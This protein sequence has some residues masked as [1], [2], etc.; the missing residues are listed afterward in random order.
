MNESSETPISEPTLPTLQDL[1]NLEIEVSGLGRGDVVHLINTHMGVMRKVM[2][3]SQD[4]GWTD[5]L[6]NAYAENLIEIRKL[7]VETRLQRAKEQ[8]LI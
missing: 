5:W 4:K 8:G 1:Q 3:Q 7:I 6:L 2:K